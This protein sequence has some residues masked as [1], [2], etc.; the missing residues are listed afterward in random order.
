MGDISPC[1]FILGW[2]FHRSH[3]PLFSWF[4]QVIVWVWAIARVSWQGLRFSIY[5]HMLQYKVLHNILLANEMVL[6]L[7][8]VTFPLCSVCKLHNEII[9]HLFYDC[10]IV[11]SIWK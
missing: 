11:K 7:R 8:K 1:S 4:G 2:A 9:M 6:K 5:M 3:K 10:L